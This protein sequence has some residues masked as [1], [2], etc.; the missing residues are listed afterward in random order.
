[1]W[2]S[3]WLIT[4]IQ[5]SNSFSELE[6]PTQHSTTLIFLLLFQVP[7]G[8]TASFTVILV[9]SHDCECS[10]S[11]DLEIHFQGGCLHLPIEA[12]IRI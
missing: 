3:L 5:N 8:L 11:Y 9:V 4:A 12:L 10:L 6:R 7:A 1:M 2:D